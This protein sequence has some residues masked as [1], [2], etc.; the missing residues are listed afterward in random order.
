MIHQASRNNY[1]SP[2]VHEELKHKGIHCN[3]KTVEKIM[4]DNGIRAKRQKKIQSNN[5]LQA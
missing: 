1:S 2:R 5:K 3:H 4:R